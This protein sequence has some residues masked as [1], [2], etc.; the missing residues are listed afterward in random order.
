MV[1]WSLK[2]YASHAVLS[3]LHKYRNTQFPFSF[4]FDIST[5]KLVLYL[6]HSISQKLSFCVCDSHVDL[7]KN[8]PSYLGKLNG[9]EIFSRSA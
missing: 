1:L 7:Q 4:L 2:K 5:V 3:F 9:L 8:T 6:L